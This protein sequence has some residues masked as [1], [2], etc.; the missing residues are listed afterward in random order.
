V[1]ARRFPPPWS[2]EDDRGE[3]FRIAALCCLHPQRDRSK[4]FAAWRRPVELSQIVIC[5]MVFCSRFADRPSAAQRYAFSGRADLLGMVCRLDKAAAALGTAAAVGRR[6]SRWL[7]T[8]PA[9]LLSVQFAFYSAILER[10][11]VLRITSGGCGFWLGNVLSEDSA[12]R[13][14]GRIGRNTLNLASARLGQRGLF[15]S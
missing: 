13:P 7:L 2:I 5:L 12:A 9:A 8:W 10:I 4:K 1:T 3:T 14:P 15:F 11:S 6:Q